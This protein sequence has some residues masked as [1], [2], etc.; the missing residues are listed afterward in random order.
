MRLGTR[1]KTSIDVTLTTPIVHMSGKEYEGIVE[2]HIVETE[3]SKERM[4]F[5][6][7]TYWIDLGKIST[8]E[9]VVPLENQFCKDIS[10][11]MTSNLPQEV[12]L[13]LSGIDE[14]GKSRIFE[15][16]FMIKKSSGQEISNIQ[17]TGMT[18]IK[19]L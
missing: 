14:T 19:V 10:K 4:G 8:L 17:F 11:R 1:T 6:G 2:A 12:D 18:D 3:E 15:G 13:K 9:I 16:K 5:F 7:F